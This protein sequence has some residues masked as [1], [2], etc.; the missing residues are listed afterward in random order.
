MWVERRDDGVLVSGFLDTSS[1]GHADARDTVLIRG[2]DPYDA[3]MRPHRFGALNACDISG[4]HRV[5]VLPVVSPVARSD[6]HLLGLVLAGHGTLEQD[7]RL[8]PLSPGS[9]VLYSG[10]RAFQLELAG[11]HRYF[12]IDFGQAGACFRQAEAVIANPELPQLA[13]GRILAA[14]LMEIAGL[15][16]QMGPLTRQEMG[17]HITCMLRTLIREASQ[18]E[19]DA[20]ARAA[21][22]DRVLAYIDQ[23]LGAELSPESI[24]SAQHISVRYLHALFKRQGDTVGHHVRCQRLERIRQDLADHDLAQVPACVIAARWGIPNPSHF[25][26]LFRAQFGVSPR[27]LRQGTRDLLREV[28]D[29]L[30]VVTV[31]VPHEAAVIVLVVFRPQPGLVQDLRALVDRGV[32][33]LPDRRP[34]RRGERDVRLAEAHPGVVLPDPEVRVPPGPVA[35]RLAEVH[36]PRAAKRREHRVVE[37]RAGSHVRA[38]ESKVI[39]H[40]A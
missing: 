9:F 10:R 11:P 25:S 26:K 16:A 19:P 3:D 38:L 13:S 7:G 36:Y 18:R 34:A 35:D 15:A 21:V 27:E 31:R 30:D 23:H 6:R 12:V 22:L 39:D 29:S 20:G 33:E 24:A 17:Q 40:G 28:T 14:T 32:E 8:A 37:R 5:G 4:G 1:S 2:P